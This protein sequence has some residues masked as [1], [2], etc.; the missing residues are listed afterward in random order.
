MINLAKPESVKWYFHPP[1]SYLSAVHLK[2]HHWQ[3]LQTKWG[4]VWMLHLTW[5][6]QPGHSWDPP[7]GS[8]KKHTLL[9]RSVSAW[10]W[11]EFIEKDLFSNN[12][13]KFLF[14][15]KHSGKLLKKE[16][17]QNSLLFTPHEKELFSLW[18]VNL[19][20]SA[21]AFSPHAELLAEHVVAFCDVI[22]ELGSKLSSPNPFHL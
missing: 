4:N 17:T 10:I 2:Q 9:M 8:K 7:A 6:M 18:R 15:W 3:P 19:G 21:V 20:H 1:P 12:L 13:F 14:S 5:V 11:R 22:C 16:V